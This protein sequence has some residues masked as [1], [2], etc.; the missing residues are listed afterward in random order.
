[1]S[2][3]KTVEELEKE[4]HTTKSKLS[5]Y[6]NKNGVKH[7]SSAKQR[8]ATLLKNQ[9][10]N[11]TKRAMATVIARLTTSTDEEFTKVRDEAYRM[12][13]VEV[14]ELTKGHE[15]EVCE[16]FLAR[17]GRRKAKD[18]QQ[19]AIT[20]IIGKRSSPDTL[21]PAPV[22]EEIPKSSDRMRI[23]GARHA[24]VYR[25]VSQERDYTAGETSVEVIV[26]VKA[27]TLRLAVA[28]VESNTGFDG[29]NKDQVVGHILSRYL[30]D[31]VQDE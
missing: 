26:K 25:P 14:K 23:Q 20:K 4:L 28:A 13:I 16:E 31:N 15:K 12:P 11:D 8:A 18:A 21:A 1:M 24:T 19:D 30:Q 7:K 29:L 27:S 3:I 6:K 2:G 5:Y 22:R 17:Q 10:W 9:E